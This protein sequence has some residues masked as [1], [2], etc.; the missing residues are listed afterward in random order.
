MTTPIVNYSYAAIAIPLVFIDTLIGVLVMKVLESIV[1]FLVT[2]E[3]EYSV[4]R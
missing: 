2:M 4:Y 1:V 3:K